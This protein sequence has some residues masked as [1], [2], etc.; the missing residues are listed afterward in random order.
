MAAIAGAINREAQQTAAKEIAEPPQRALRLDSKDLF[1]KAR[2]VEYCMAGG[3]AACVLRS[4][5]N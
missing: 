1:K 3:F 2:E 5:I 4:S